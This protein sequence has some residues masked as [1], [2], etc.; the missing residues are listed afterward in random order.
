[1]FSLIIHTVI[2]IHT[3]QNKIQNTIMYDVIWNYFVYC[4]VFLKLYVIFLCC[5]SCPNF[6]PFAS[7]HP[8]C[9]S[10][11][12]HTVVHDLGSCMYVLWAAVF[13]TLYFTS[14]W[15]FCDYQFVL[16]NPFTFST[17]PAN[18][19]PSGNHQNALCVCNSVSVLHACLFC[20]LDPVVDRSEAAGTQVIDVMNV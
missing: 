5:Y 17:L 3:S 8:V 7:L 12:L 2:C 16:L 11:N 1:M 19:F 6:T 10:G 18:P 13:P 15:L 9:P 20:F 4:C 14:P